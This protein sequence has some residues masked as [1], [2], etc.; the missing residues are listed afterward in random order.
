MVVAAPVLFEKELVAWMADTV[1]LSDEVREDAR[2]QIRSMVGASIYAARRPLGT[3][4]LALTLERIGG[5]VGYHLQNQIDVVQQIIDITVW[6]KEIKTGTPATL[7]ALNMCEYIR[8]LL[9]AFRGTIGAVTVQQVELENEPF[10]DAVSPADASDNWAFR[11][12]M[13]YAFWFRLATLPA[14]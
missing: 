14:D 5:D 7:H 12:V 13:P 11:Y 3:G 8:R 4:P 9:S 2:T 10:A 6:A 1:P